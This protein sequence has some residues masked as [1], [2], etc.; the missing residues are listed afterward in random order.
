ML[1]F[2]TRTLV[3][4]WVFDGGHGSPDMGGVSADG[5]LLWLT[6]RYDGEV[7]A[8]STDT[9]LLVVPPIKVGKGPHGA[10]RVAPARALLDGPHRHL[11]VAARYRTGRAVGSPDGT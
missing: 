10:V 2:A 8:I 1:D 9:G 6:G 4:K 5:K 7:Y 11:P 3:A